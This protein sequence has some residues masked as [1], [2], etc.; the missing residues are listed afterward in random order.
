MEY[1]IRI[2]NGDGTFFDDDEEIYS[3]IDEAEYWAERIIAG[4]HWEIVER[5]N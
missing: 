3:S 5:G 2:F 4:A 1:V